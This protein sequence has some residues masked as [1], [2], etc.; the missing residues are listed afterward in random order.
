MSME[1]SMW[2]DLRLQLGMELDSPFLYPGSIRGS[3]YQRATQ[4]PG[5][6]PV[7]ED[8]AREL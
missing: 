3:Q 5:G 7:S 2:L 1:C 8:P 6:G 4:D